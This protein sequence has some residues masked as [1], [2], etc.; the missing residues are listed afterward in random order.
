MNWSRLSFEDVELIT[1][2]YEIRDLENNYDIY[3]EREQYF[4]IDVQNPPDI[5][6]NRCRDW[7]LKYL[8]KY[9]KIKD[10]DEFYRKYLRKEYIQPEGEWTKITKFYSDHSIIPSVMLPKKEG[11]Y[12]GY[13]ADIKIMNIIF[14]EVYCSLV[15]YLKSIT[16]VEIIDKSSIDIDKPDPNSNI[17]ETSF[18]HHK[19]DDHQINVIGGIFKGELEVVKHEDNIIEC[20]S[21]KIHRGKSFKAAY[22]STLVGKS[23]QECLNGLVQIP[24]YETT[25]VKYEKP[26]SEF[27][28]YFYYDTYVI[29]K[30]HDN[31]F[32]DE[33]IFTGETLPDNSFTNLKCNVFTCP[34]LKIVGNNCFSRCDINV[35]E[36]VIVELGEDC[37]MGSKID[38]LRFNG[39]ERFNSTIVNDYARIKN[40]VL[41]SFIELNNEV[42]ICANSIH[43]PNLIKLNADMTIKSKYL[44]MKK[45]QVINGVINIHKRP[46]EKLELPNLQ[47]VNS[48]IFDGCAKHMIIKCTTKIDKISSGYYITYDKIN[49]KDVN[50][51]I[52]KLENKKIKMNIYAPDTYIY[53]RDDRFVK[54][55]NIECPGV[56][57]FTKKVT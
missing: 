6:Y 25:T 39:L 12:C 26:K 10:N 19:Y 56:G 22:H 27:H 43:F 38:L 29:D 32:A 45:L 52:N 14:Q 37:F 24:T 2:E 46:L 21:V 15:E 44:H 8:G 51:Y 31:I 42:D 30:P 4:V 53:I 23:L 35:F 54:T 41:P 5:Y 16:D 33:V 13:F 7:Y 36:N 40:V 49:S 55:I 11:K 9:Y 20:K 34:N 1:S 18:I 17:L 3:Y 28:P 57:S 50:C 47:E 48:F